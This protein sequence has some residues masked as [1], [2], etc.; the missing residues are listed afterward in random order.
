V[1]ACIG[2]SCLINTIAILNIQRFLK[3]I[4]DIELTLATPPL[5]NLLE[6]PWFC[7]TI[8]ASFMHA[9]KTPR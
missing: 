4:M 7:T 9:G 8:F 1:P 2:D 3:E 5:W 6:R